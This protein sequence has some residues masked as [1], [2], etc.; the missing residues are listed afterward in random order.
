MTVDA[1]L[2][3]LAEVV[4]V[5]FPHWKVTFFPPFHSVFLQSHYAQ[6]TPKWGAR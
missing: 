3:H 2:D 5:R 4:F 6:P 1:D